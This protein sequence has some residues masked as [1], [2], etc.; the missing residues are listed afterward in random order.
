MKLNQWLG[1]LPIVRES[2]LDEILRLSTHTTPWSIYSGRDSVN[3]N[4]QRKR[5]MSRSPNPCPSKDATCSNHPVFIS[6]EKFARTNLCFS[7]AHTNDATVTKPYFRNKLWTKVTS[8]RGTRQHE[9]IWNT[10]DNKPKCQTKFQW[11]RTQFQIMHQKNVDNNHT[12]SSDLRHQ[13]LQ[14]FTPI[15]Q[16]VIHQK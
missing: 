15:S 8:A 6:I 16:N 7:V 2:A 4:T 3:E 12:S 1:W 11:S 14:F 10:K 9:T 5:V 13:P